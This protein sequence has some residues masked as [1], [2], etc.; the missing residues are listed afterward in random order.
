MDTIA[1][2]AALTVM[3]A[4]IA[5]GRCLKHRVVALLNKARDYR[6]IVGDP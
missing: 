1:L 5:M 4:I 3:G 6:E 2:L